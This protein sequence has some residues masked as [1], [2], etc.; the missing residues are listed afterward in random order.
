MDKK[1]KQKKK[2]LKLAQ[3][4]ARLSSQYTHATK[5]HDELLYEMGYEI[6]HDGGPGF[7]EDLTFPD[8]YV[9]KIDYGGGVTMEDI[10]RL[11]SAL[12]KKET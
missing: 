11:L 9:D 10:D 8:W 2:L 12:K 7:R 5:E 4:L 1:E 6:C 3:K